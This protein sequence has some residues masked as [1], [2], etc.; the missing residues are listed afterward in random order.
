MARCGRCRVVTVPDNQA[1]CVDCNEN[2]NPSNYVGGVHISQVELPD[3]WTPAYVDPG[4]IDGHPGLNWY[5]RVEKVHGRDL[6]PGQWLDSLDHSGARTIHHITELTTDSRL[7]SFSDI[8]G[9]SEVVRTDV[10]YDVVDPASQVAPD[11][12]PVGGIGPRPPR[13]SNPDVCIRCR[14]APSRNPWGC[15]TTCGMAEAMDV[16]VSA[17]HGLLG[18]TRTDDEV[19]RDI[20][21][22]GD[23]LLN[24]VLADAEA[25]RLAVEPNIRAFEASRRRKKLRRKRL[26]QLAFVA[27]L[28]VVALLAAAAIG[29]L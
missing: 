15:C 14:V 3:P 8:D 20:R 10:L 18:D 2:D 23:L 21:A 25:Q 6:K 17:L 22:D 11:G 28:A 12:T 19:L 7:V 5:T 4:T 27:A 16:P 29:R 9:D 26:R 24:D 13:G 1:W